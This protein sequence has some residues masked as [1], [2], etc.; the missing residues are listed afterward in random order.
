MIVA[1]YALHYGSDYLKYSLKSIYDRVDK[2]VIVYSPL[3]SYGTTQTIPNPDTASSMLDTVLQFPDPYNKISWFTQQFGSEGEHRD[4]AVG[5]CKELGARRILVVDADEIWDVDTLEEFCLKLV[6]EKNI[7]WQLIRMNTLWRSFNHHCI[8]DMWPTRGINLE[9]KEHHGYTQAR[10]H[11]FGYARE[12]KHI[13]YKMSI[14]GH[15]HEIRPEWLQKFKNWKPDALDLQLHFDVHPT[16]VNTWTVVPFDQSR[17][18]KIMEQHP[19]W[20]RPVI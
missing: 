7:R 12:L 19:Y 9:A 8:D 16:C 15:K 10:V 11:H 2:I 1:Y 5:K 4:F 13:E 17:L 20:D 18:P 3:P 14:H 6:G